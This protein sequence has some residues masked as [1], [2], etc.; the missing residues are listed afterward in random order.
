MSP[1][2]FFKDSSPSSSHNR[3]SPP[4]NDLLP[5]PPASS[6]CPFSIRRLNPTTHL[7]RENDAY[8]EYPHIY[9][10]LATTR[11]RFW[12]A[13]HVLVLS[14][15]GCGGEVANA[16]FDAEDPTTGPEM[17]NIRT[18]LEF[19]LNPGGNMP[20]LV[21]TTHCHYDHI[22]GIGYLPPTCSGK[23][24]PSPVLERSD[25]PAMGGKRLLPTASQNPLPN[26]RTLP[27]PLSPPTT[28]LSSSHSP[29]FIT[30]YSHLMKH[31]FYPIVHRPTPHYTIGIWAHDRQ[32][33]VYRY[34]DHEVINVPIDTGITIL[35]TPG[36][37]PDSLSWYDEVERSVSVG[38]SLYE[39]ESTDS[40]GEVGGERG[41]GSEPPMP[42]I[43]TNESDLGDWW[44]SLKKVIEFVREKNK[45]G[46]DDV[47]KKVA[48]KEHA[49]QQVDDD[50]DDDWVLVPSYQFTSPRHQ[51]R[52]RP[53]SH[54]IKPV[55]KPRLTLS[56]AHV[57]AS[58][59]A[60]TCLIA[61]Q[62]FVARILRNEVPFRLVK[63]VKTGEM[64]GLWDD[65]L[66]EERR[67]LKG[68]QKGRFSVQSPLWVTEEGRKRIPREEWEGI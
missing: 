29:T 54:T 60:E 40:R 45:E 43:F 10:K 63:E 15:T 62:T 50:D 53:S 37:T 27:L 17:W 66:D 64:V 35:H 16:D 42:T 68:N 46:E 6:A 3:D 39:R 61:I 8:G 31:S 9:A 12:K 48:Q 11:S 36:H 32:H 13:K 19:T 51:R 14:D 44:E 34:S 2:S 23:C 41:W 38:D 47:A 5:I 1:P 7:I 30:P 20:Y 67:D 59:D 58:V 57:T 21:M 33:L 56:A 49:K 28:V 4:P 26:R 55:C 18:F 52:P 24:C 25:C 22:L 65:M